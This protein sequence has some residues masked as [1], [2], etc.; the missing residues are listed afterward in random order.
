MFLKYEYNNNYYELEFNGIKVFQ[1]PFVNKITKSFYEKSIKSEFVEAN[2][3]KNNVFLISDFTKVMDLLDL[4]KSST[5]YKELLDKSIN[6]NLINEDLI[7]E[8]MNNIN[9]KFDC[10]ILQDKKDWHKIILNLWEL[11]DGLYLNKKIFK[12]ILESNFYSEKITFIIHDVDWLQVDDVKN[13]INR[14]NFIF[15]T[16]DLRLNIKNISNI[17]TL[18]ILEDKLIEI[19]DSD[20]ILSYLENKTRYHMS[21]KILKNFFDMKNDEISQKI[22]FSLKNI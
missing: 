16:N 10:S 22:L 15:I 9:E 6:S 14:F 2:I 5:I 20:K 12:K 18:V 21:N 3:F 11:N 1:T 19:L 17:E 7:S 13:Y 4:S 8:I